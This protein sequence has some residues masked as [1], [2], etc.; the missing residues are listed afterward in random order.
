MSTLL[1][2]LRVSDDGGDPAG[3]VRLVRVRVSRH[4][5]GQRE[6]RDDDLLA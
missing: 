3:P 6:R 4:G 2:L 1:L 5:Q